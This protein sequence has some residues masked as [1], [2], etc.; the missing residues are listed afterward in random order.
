MDDG[1]GEPSQTKI[2]F[3][4]ARTLLSSIK[5]DVEASK[6]LGVPLFDRTRAFLGVE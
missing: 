3:A 5:L 2:Y 1:T 6:K 4:G